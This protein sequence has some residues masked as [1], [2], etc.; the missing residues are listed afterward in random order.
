MTDTSAA[1]K[2]LKSFT[3][4]AN[5]PHP[6]AL[7][8]PATTGPA[9]AFFFFVSSLGKNTG[10]LRMMDWADWHGWMTFP[11]RRAWWVRRISSSLYG[12]FSPCLCQSGL[13]PHN[14]SLINDLRPGWIGWAWNEN[15]VLLYIY[16]HTHI[17]QDSLTSH[18]SLLR[19][20]T[21]GNL[22]PE[23]IMS[24]QLI[25]FL[26][27][28]GETGEV[29]HIVWEQNV[30]CVVSVANVTSY[31][32]PPWPGHFVF[33]WLLAHTWLILLL[34]FIFH[35]TC[36]QPPPPEP[37][38]PPPRWFSVFCHWSMACWFL[39]EHGP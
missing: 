19:Q 16:I 39:F 30:R 11:C 14:H 26:F 12:N 18:S 23:V 28:A 22:K 7:R 3:L 17:L 27:W 2:T 29:K 38:P 25:S 31:C 34:S 1:D 36:L 32:L 13:F 5:R 21:D 10:A 20:N 15:Q 6:T 8:L 24:E 33:S 35:M 9:C 4:T 37:I